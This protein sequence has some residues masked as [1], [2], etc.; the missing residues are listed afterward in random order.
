MRPRSPIYSD[1][2]LCNGDRC[3]WQSSRSSSRSRRGKKPR[4]AR[5]GN[6]LFA[7]NGLS[8]KNPNRSLERESARER[9]R[10]GGGGGGGRRERKR[11]ARV[12]RT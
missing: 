10:E 9:E 7:R 8:P 6:E 5:A 4:R 12:G 3:T 11:G 2:A 1:L